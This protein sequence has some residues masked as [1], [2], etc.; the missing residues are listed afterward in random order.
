MTC[1][2]ESKFTCSHSNNLLQIED[3]QLC[4]GINDCLNELASD[5]CSCN[6]T[7]KSV[8]TNGKCILTQNLCDG[9]DDC[10][11]GEESDEKN[12]AN[13]TKK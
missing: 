11:D 8:C 3:D 5:E 9:V 7:I 4:N 10:Q 13:K 12:C 1:F 6:T 2:S